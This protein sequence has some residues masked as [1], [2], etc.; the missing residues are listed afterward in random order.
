M[1]ALLYNKT[2]GQVQMIALNT[3]GVLYIVEKGDTVHSVADL[4]G[5]TIVASGQGSTAEYALNYILAANGLEVGKDVMVEYKSEH[6]EAAT[7][8]AAGQADVAL[9]PE[10][11][12]TSTLLKDGTLRVALDLTQEWD[13]IAQDEGTDSAMAMGCLIV[14]KEFAQQNPAALDAFLAEYEAS[15]SFVNENLD[16]A[17]ELIVQYGIMAQA[18]AAKKALPGCN[19]VFVSGQAMKDAIVPFLQVLHTAN[20]ASVGGAMPADDFFY[21]AQ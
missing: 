20:P 1:A 16:Q 4:A 8:L 7:L 17:S 12:V 18:A 5:K 21:I 3:L 15:T 14:R 10:P 13:A 6:A 9:L 11:F 19:I 2:K